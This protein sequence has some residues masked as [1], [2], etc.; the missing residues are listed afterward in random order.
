M[1]SS[2]A[3]ELNMVRGISSWRPREHAPQQS[4]LFYR[5]RR[6]SA[7]CTGAADPGAAAC[8]FPGLDRVVKG[9]ELMARPAYGGR[10]NCESYHSI[11]LRRW[12]REGRLQPGQWFSCSWTC[13]GEPSGSIS[14]RTET[15]TVV[16][17][18]RFRG[19]EST[20][21]KSVEQRV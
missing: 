19:M 14:V 2:P 16:L 11:D 18:F 12:H 17:S 5:F 7:R 20:Q 3:R 9:G 4:E 1:A 21:W 13:G 6:L 15:D 8:A 10:P